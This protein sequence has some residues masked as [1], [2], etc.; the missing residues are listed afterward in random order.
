[1]DL[2]LGAPIEESLILSGVDMQQKI[3]ELMEKEFTG[4]IIAAI[5]GYDGIEEGAILFRKGTITAAAY[6]FMAHNKKIEGEK[7]LQLM[8]NSFNADK[9]IA[10]IYSLSLQHMDL[11]LAF[12]EKMTLNTKIDQKNLQKIFPKKYSQDYAK[13]IIQKTE[14]T[15]KYEIFKKSGLSGLARKI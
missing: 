9:G 12:H 14:E 4:Y 10:D 6:D 2:P 11:V 8:L 3:K 5:D 13:Q 7:A 1:M 15:T